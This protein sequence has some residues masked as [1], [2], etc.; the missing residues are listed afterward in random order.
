MQL[1]LNNLSHITGKSR[2]VTPYGAVTLCS[3]RPVLGVRERGKRCFD[4]ESECM[5]R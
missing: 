1:N 4:G 2:K 5:K 3:P